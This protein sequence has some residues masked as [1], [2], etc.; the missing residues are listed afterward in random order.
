MIGLNFS[1]FKDGQD[2]LNKTGM[3]H[4]QAILFLTDELKKRGVF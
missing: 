3:T 1:Q 4:D 2:F